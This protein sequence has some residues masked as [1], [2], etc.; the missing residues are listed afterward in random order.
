MLFT[1]LNV[2]STGKD[3]INLHLEKVQ[4][5]DKYSPNNGNV[6]ACL[7]VSG[8]AFVTTGLLTSPEWYVDG[9]KKG[10][11]GNPSRAAALISGTVLLGTGIIITIKK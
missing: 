9:T 5:K 8:L 2:F 4:Y 1:T 6:G 11:F 7:L 3:R 10:F